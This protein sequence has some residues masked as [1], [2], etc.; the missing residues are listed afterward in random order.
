MFRFL[1]R[2]RWILIAAMAL[3]C[4]S[5]VFFMSSG[6]GRNRQGGGVV[7]YGTI[8]GHELTGEEV[9]QAQRDFYLFFLVNYGE[10]PDKSRNITQNQIEQQTYLNLM[11]MRKAKSLGVSVP[12]DVVADAASQMLRSQG[13]ARALGVS[14]QAVQL[15]QLDPLLKQKGFTM[16]DFQHSVRSQLIVEQLRLTLG[17]AGS[18]VTPQE[19]GALYDR[20][21]QEISAQAVFFSVT[22]Y[23]AQVPAPAAAVG[24]F[25]TNNMAYYRVPDRLQVNYV[26]FNIT[27]YLADAKAEWAKT[28]FEQTVD[29]VY[30]EYGATEFKDA[31]TPDEAKEKIRDLLIRRRALGDVAAKA[32]QFKTT[33]WEMTPVELNNIATVAKQSGLTVKLSEP[34]A[35]GS[36]PADFVN[37]PAAAKVPFTLSKDSPFSDLIP[38]EDGIYVV[39]LAKELPSEIPSFSEI[40]ARVEQ[41]FRMQSA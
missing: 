40:H 9:G 1:R 27:N 28:N 15:S 24:E 33:L 10:W 5:F 16:A 26:W 11:F 25:F 39:G 37:A 19:A 23:M 36:Q 32:N 6:P 21:H 29:N 8:Y 41:D 7:S 3:T 20:E 17:L 30:R 34:F 4:I 13:L 12:D 35:E 22:N 18:L 31:K 2:H 14:G 38:G